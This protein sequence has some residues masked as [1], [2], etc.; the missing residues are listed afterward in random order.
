MRANSVFQKD[1]SPASASSRFS[2][3]VNLLEY[4]RLLKLPPDSGLRD[5]RLGQREQIQLGPNRTVPESGRVFPVMTSIMVVLPAPLG[6]MTQRSS[7]G[8]TCSVRSLSALKPSKLTVSFSR[9][10]SFAANAHFWMAPGVRLELAAAPCVFLSSCAAGQQA[11][12]PARQKQRHQDE[13]RAERVV[14]CFGNRAGEIGFCVVH[15]IRPGGRTI[16]RPP[17]SDRYPDDDFNRVD[18]REFAG[19]MMPICGT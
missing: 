10:E 1:L 11:D 3:T 15:K 17:S 12:D 5:F 2:K 13:Q 6:P 18:W 8:S 4:R 16:K 14:P 9:Y 7:P 19:L